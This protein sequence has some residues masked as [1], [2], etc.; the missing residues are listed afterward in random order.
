MARGDA[1][2]VKAVMLIGLQRDRVVRPDEREDLFAALAA[3]AMKDARNNCDA[4]PW[5][6]RDRLT[7]VPMSQT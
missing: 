4:M 5:R 7:Y 1:D 3:N 2:D 6:R